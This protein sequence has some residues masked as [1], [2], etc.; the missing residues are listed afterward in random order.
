MLSRNFKGK[1]DMKWK[2][3]NESLMDLFLSELKDSVRSLIFSSFFH[4]FNKSRGNIA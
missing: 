2:I 4:F 1:E 3:G